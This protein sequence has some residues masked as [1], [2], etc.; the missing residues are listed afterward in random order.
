[1]QDKAAIQPLLQRA[2]NLME[3]ASNWQRKA[4]KRAHIVG[5]QGEKRRLRYLYREARNVVDWTEHCAYDLLKFE[6]TAQSGS[7]DVSSLMCCMS[8]MNGMI[9]KLWVIYNEA[10]QIANELVVAKCRNFAKPIYDYVDKLFNILA[11]LQ[12]TQIEYE[13]AK[14]EYH[15]I[16]RYQVGWENVHDDYEDKE[17][18]Q[19]YSDYK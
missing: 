17:E 10:H 4:A 12:R 6:I 13:K 3:T 1:M 9:E 14:Y 11:E 15:H 18:S 8:T 19:G 16:S 5:L 7:V 2:L